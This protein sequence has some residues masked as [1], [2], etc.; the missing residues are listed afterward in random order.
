M[1]PSL[2]RLLKQDLDL[3]R[4]GRS[5]GMVVLSPT[6]ELAIQIAD[7]AEQLLQYHPKAEGLSVACL[8]G[9]VKMQR[10]TRLLT[11]GTSPHRLPAIVVSTPGRLLDHLEGDTRLGRNDRFADIVRDT[12]IVVLDETDRLW[13]NHQKEVKKILSFF[14]RSEKRQ[15]LLFSAT[16]SRSIR[17]LL[18]ASVLKGRD[19]LEVDCLDDG[20]DKDK[21]R[22]EITKAAAISERIQQSYVVLD[23]MSQYIPLLLAI[24]RREQHKNRDDF[25]ILVFFPTSR[26]VRFFYQFFTLGDVNMG[27]GVKNSDDNLWEIH[28]RMSQSSRS[29]A[30]NAFRN[31]RTG[32]LLSSD[33]SAR[34]L[35]YPDVTMVVQMGTPSKESNYVHR[36][37]RTGRA[38]R[39]G[40]GILVLLPFEDGNN[41]INL[42]KG[43]L[44]KDKKLL[45]WYEKDQEGIKGGSTESTP[46]LFRDCHDDLE[47]TRAKIRS[48]HVILTPSAEAAFKSFLAH[49]SAM[50]QYSE[51]KKDSPLMPTE[52][53]AYAED[54][55]KA[56]GI[57][58]LPELD[59]KVATRIG[60]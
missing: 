11:G 29:R 2:E 50:A 9:G 4:P 40:C 51:G 24:I 46:S 60:L 21:E 47:S 26:V 1:L 23:H 58:D 39:A 48:G 52:I 34:G 7:Q 43:I 57:V 30:S 44:G 16:F 25:K 38:G 12:K 10:D 17:R 13:E 3:Y 31:A 56:L 53:M 6:R 22:P 19:A 55:A 20:G 32:I 54:F 42:S 41:L 59:E 28:S 45:A 15:M 33:V 49:Y 35:D 18:K 36:L 5:I 14:A 8:Y 27:M 37:G